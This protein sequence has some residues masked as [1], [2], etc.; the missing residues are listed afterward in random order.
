MVT[1]SRSWAR[2]GDGPVR[3]AVVG[4][5]VAEGGEQRVARLARQPFLGEAAQGLERVAHLLDVGLASVAE[6]EMLLEARKVLCG[7][8][9]LE[10]GGDQIDHLAAGHV[11][12]S[13]SERWRSSAARTL[14]L[15]RC[16]R[17]RSLPTL[18][19]RTVAASASDQPRR[20]RSVM[21]SRWRGASDAIVPSSTARVCSSSIHASGS[22]HRAGGLA[23]H[24]GRS[25][26][27]FWK[28]AGS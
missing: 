13:S 28:R 6:R 19:P 27:G 11:V 16:R 17:T 23:H 1:S 26:P 21:T 4:L 9:A 3:S 8:V 15:A 12:P 14:A 5:P 22:P 18:T 7:Q 25:W 2:D 10:E 20:S 24:P